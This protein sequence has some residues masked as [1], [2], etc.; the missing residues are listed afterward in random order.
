MT[1][2][3]S[4]IFLYLVNMFGLVFFQRAQVLLGIARQWGR[5]IL[6][7][8]PRSDVRILIYRTWATPGVPKVR[9][10]TL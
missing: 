10:C 3:L 4:V 1:P 9:S 7:Q 2:G 6:S 5:A 8:K